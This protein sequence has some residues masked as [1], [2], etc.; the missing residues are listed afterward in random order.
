MEIRLTVTVPGQQP[1][2]HLLVD[3]TTYTVGRSADCDIAIA[4]TYVSRTPMRIEWT[5]LGFDIVDT[6]HRNP[7]VINGYPLAGRAQ[8][9]GGDSIT[10]GDVS[11]SVEA[12]GTEPADPEA[13][14]VPTAAQR[15]PVAA[16]P[17]TP[18]PPGG[19][20]PPPPPGGRRTVNAGV[21]RI[22]DRD[23]H[24]TEYPIDAMSIVV[25]R[26]NDVEIQTAPDDV[27]VD[28]R[29]FRIRADAKGVFIEDTS[30]GGT[31]IDGRRLPANRATELREQQV[32]RF[33]NYEAELLP[34]QTETPG[35]ATP[36]T[37]PERQA[38]ISVS[39]APPTQPIAAGGV[40]TAMVTVANRGRTVDQISL[41]V[42]DVDP[43][44][45]EIRRPTVPLVPGASDEIAV[46]IK[47]PK[48]PKALAGEH[49]FAVVATSAQAGAEVRALSRFTILPFE[50]FDF[51][52]RPRGNK[53]RF[54][55]TARNNGSVTSTHALSATNDDE[56]LKFV[57]EAE[58]IEL[59]PGSERELELRVRPRRRN[60]FGQVKSYRLQVEARPEGKTTTRGA[61][62]ASYSYR[63]PL[64]RW[65]AMLMP[66]LV[67]FGL[68][69]ALLI[70]RG[71]LTRLPG[72]IDGWFG[73]GKDDTPAATA[74]ARPAT[75]AS[76]AATTAGAVTTPA[77]SAACASLAP[78]C[79]A[80]VVNSPQ[81]GTGL[82]M[83]SGAGVEFPDVKT[84]AGDTRLFNGTQLK[85]ISGPTTNGSYVWWE[86]QLADGQ[87]VF[88]AEGE[89]NQ[90]A[91]PESQGPWIQVVP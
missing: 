43:T 56:A 3:G 5:G 38:P 1:F 37:P 30:A 4:S 23:G 41:R 71:N 61:A 69:G 75:T 29:H 54:R 70:S 16:A 45:I 48:T 9:R 22:R 15:R 34:N 62:T 46:V 80:V 50:A 39:M 13:T 6:A 19:P 52:C 28:R 58:Q 36:G 53:G 64:R 18:P 91:N 17:S 85:L 33:G 42:V 72:I 2:H 63:P 68:G 76:P 59:E 84:T 82:R 27:S 31:F 86:V 7:V 78:G 66:F 65:R 77:T 55:L 40:G 73:G 79:N 67:A 83:R 11:I 81:N 51:A 20:T 26:G 12:V 89:V 24:I 44:W 88:V 14:M 32:I 90:R 47:P 49:S 25:G 87:R 57:F 35:G 10:I 8:L 74:T 21:L 60:P